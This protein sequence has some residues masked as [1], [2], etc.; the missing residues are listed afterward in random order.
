LLAQAFSPLGEGK[1]KRLLRGEG[2]PTVTADIERERRK[3][4]RERR[5]V[6]AGSVLTPG[7][8]FMP[9]TISEG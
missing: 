7:N 8:P 4:Q 9:Q 3:S 5:G 6:G 1:K 2:S